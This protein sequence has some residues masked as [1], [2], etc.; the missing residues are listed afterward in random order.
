MEEAGEDDEQ[1]TFIAEDVNAI[2]KE[3]IHAD[4]HVPFLQPRCRRKN[5]FLCCCHNFSCSSHRVGTCAHGAV[6]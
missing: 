3:V 5:N 4:S 6:D 2:I 1:T